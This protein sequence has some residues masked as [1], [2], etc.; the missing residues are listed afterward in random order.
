[1]T[2]LALVSRLY[3][4]HGFL[5]LDLLKELNPQINDLDK[6]SEGDRI[7]IPPLNRETLL[8]QQ[9]DGSYRLIFSS[10]RQRREAERCRQMLLAQGYTAVILPQ[11]ISSTLKLYRI[12]IDGLR[13]VTAIE[14]AWKLAL[15]Q[16]FASLARSKGK[17]PA[18]AEP[19]LSD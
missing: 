15:T 1:M 19:V 16:D 13:E 5:A 9:M 14:K 11:Q 3:G 8:R 6:V 2:V 10:F 12:E 17:A 4:D 7:W 18:E